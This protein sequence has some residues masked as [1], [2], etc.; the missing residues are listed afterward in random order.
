M[1]GNVPVTSNRLQMCVLFFV[2][3]FPF[4]NMAPPKIKSNRWEKIQPPKK[5]TKTSS[6]LKKVL[7]IEDREAFLINVFLFVNL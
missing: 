1:N 4:S 2:N 3:F 7:I 5:Q 6:M